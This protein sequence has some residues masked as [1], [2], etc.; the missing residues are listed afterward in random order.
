MQTIFPILR[1]ADARAA[2]QWLTDA[3]GFVLVFSV[4]ESGPY[5]RHAQLQLGSSIVM[6]GSVRPDE[7]LSSPAITGAPT[8]ALCIHVEDVHA[9][10]RRAQASGAHV[11]SPPSISDV[12]YLEFHV[13]DPEG[14]PWTF[15]SFQP[16]ST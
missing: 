1:Y 15:S 11:L 9:V 8:Q 4:P 5:V 14:H 13:S 6:L 2:I 7:G 3:F 16:S 10:F 12:G